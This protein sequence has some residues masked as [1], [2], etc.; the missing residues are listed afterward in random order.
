MI[1]LYSKADLKAI[2][3]FQAFYLWLLDRTGVYLATVNMVLYLVSFGFWIT[4][5]GKVS[6]IGL[7]LLAIVGLMN[8]IRYWW[9]EKEQYD[10]LNAGAMS[11]EASRF[12]QWGN[13]YFIAIT[14]WDMV[15]FHALDLCFD[16]C[17]LAIQ[18]SM[19]VKIRERD[20]KPFFE[21]KK[22]LAPQAR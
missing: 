7:A 14:I 9:Q 11:F 21:P 16:L 19:T 2:E 4:K 3:G 22:E 5:D 15:F 6:L 8:M 20:K 10:T 18:Y 1:S 12:R 17:M 13:G